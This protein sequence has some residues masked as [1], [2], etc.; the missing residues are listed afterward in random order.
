[1]IGRVFLNNLADQATLLDFSSLLSVAHKSDGTE[2]RRPPL[3]TS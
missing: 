2:Q 1:M 3:G